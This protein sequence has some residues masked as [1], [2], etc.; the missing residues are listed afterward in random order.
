ML[1]VCPRKELYEKRRELVKKLNGDVFW[2]RSQWPRKLQIPIWK[3]PLNDKDTFQVSLFLLG[4]GCSEF[5]VVEWILIS[6]LT[7]AA[8]HKKW[9]KRIKQLDFVI[10]NIDKKN[11]SWFYYDLHHKGLFYF[12]GSRK[13]P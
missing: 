10:K 11:D 5:I 13:R 9:E 4:N 7:W 12:N 3:K 6:L 2:S 1:V 8:D